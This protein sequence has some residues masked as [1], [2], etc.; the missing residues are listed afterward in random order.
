MPI[1]ITSGSGLSRRATP[2]LIISGIGRKPPL[3]SGANPSLIGA[4]GAVSVTCRPIATRGFAGIEV[5][6][7][8]ACVGI[9][10][11]RRHHHRGGVETP[12]RD[13]L[14]D[15]LVDARRMP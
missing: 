8:A 9:E 3:R 15:G 6:K 12:A 13:Q 2:R 10:M 1:S 5:I 14:A 11:R 4:N 7:R